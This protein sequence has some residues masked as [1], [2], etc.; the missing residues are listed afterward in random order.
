MVS[1]WSKG[2][3]GTRV[4]FGFLRHKLLFGV[5]FAEQTHWQGQEKSGGKLK[6]ALTIV[7]MYQSYQNFALVE[8]IWI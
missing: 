5:D 7:G 3:K 2:S 4:K 8:Q 6:F 1:K